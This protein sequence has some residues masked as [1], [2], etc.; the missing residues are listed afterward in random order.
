M[1]PDERHADFSYEGEGGRWTMHCPRGHEWK[2]TYSQTTV[3]VGLEPV[4]CPFCGEEG[5]CVAP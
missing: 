5:A 3:G 2:A 4:D 1:D